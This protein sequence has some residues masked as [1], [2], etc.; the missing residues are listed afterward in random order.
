MSYSIILQKWIT[1]QGAAGPAVITQPENS[2]ADLFPYSDVT[3]F[4]EVSNVS[5]APTIAYQTSPT[6]DEVLFTNLEPPRIAL[7]GVNTYIYR[8]ATAA[9]PIARYLRW[10]IGTGAIGAWNCTFRIWLAATMSRH[11]SI[12][13]AH[14]DLYA[15]ESARDIAITMDPYARFLSA[16]RPG[17]L[18]NTQPSTDTHT[19]LLSAL[20]SGQLAMRPGIRS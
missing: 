9:L 1:L 8:Y 15:G 4:V 13:F 3:V 17:H 7:V 5:N 16:L 6:R 20:R 19:R 11:L 18:A 12:D 10:Q 2:Y 14:K